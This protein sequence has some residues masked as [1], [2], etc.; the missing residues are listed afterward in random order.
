[1]ASSLVSCCVQ[2][3]DWGREG[4]SNQTAVADAM[5]R[6]ARKWEPDFI[7][8]T[9]DNFYESGLTSVEDPQ[10]SRSFSEVY[11]DK[12]LQ[13]GW[14]STCISHSS[15]TTATRQSACKRACACASSGD[16][17]TSF[18]ECLVRRHKPLHPNISMGFLKA[19]WP[20][21][22]LCILSR[23]HAVLSSAWCGASTMPPPVAAH[24][25]HGFG[26]VS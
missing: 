15:G 5:A 12:S 14:V 26:Y 18:S 16:G 13:V 3:G 23:T 19:F 9:G 25:L 6:L 4:N 24:N 21:V 10:F 2:V 20:A 8:S 17:D 22:R 1:M 7:I 11:K